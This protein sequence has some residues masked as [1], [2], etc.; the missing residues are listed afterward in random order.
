[1]TSSSQKPVVFHL[2]TSLGVGGCERMLLK[3]VPKLK[4]A[5]HHVISLLP[6]QSLGP[7][8][9]AAGVTVHY[10]NARN[11][12]DWK[13]VQRFKKLIRTHSP[14]LLITYLAHADM[15]GRWWGFFY[16]IPHRMGAIRAT[17]PEWRFWPIWLFE[18]CTSWMVEGYIAVS[19]SA[20]DFY[21]RRL[22]I[23][24]RRITVIPNG[25][26]PKQFSVSIDR[27]AF[28]KK[29]NLPADA[30]VFTYVAKLRIAQKNHAFLL[31]VFTQLSKNF[32][33][34][35]LLIVGDGPDRAAVETDVKTLALTEK[36]HLLG[37]RSDVPEL[38]NLTDI[39]VFPT[40]YEGL[41]N[42]LLEACAAGTALVASDIPENREIINFKTPAILCDPTD[43]KAWV[44]TLTKLLNESPSREQV[45]K[46]VLK[47][48]HDFDVNALSSQLDDTLYKAMGL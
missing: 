48:A 39:F 46:A 21:A 12:L 41:S 6:K 22:R 45:S 7:Q 37:D 9:E 17:L 43:K 32:P 35:H 5:N 8:L 34:L 11:L 31:R 36:V 20:K 47:R 30:L 18:W 19:Q 16:R 29:L 33:H 13:A 14:Q 15:F 42:A 23:N 38:L 10:L 1:M 28:L 40:L 44:E 3:M 24:P 27:A 4:R 25:I 26:D 2:I